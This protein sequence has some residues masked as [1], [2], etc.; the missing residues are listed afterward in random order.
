MSMEYEL[1]ILRKTLIVI[2][3]LTQILGL[4]TYDVN[5]DTLHIKNNPFKLIYS[6]ILP[7]VILFNY[8]KFGIAI[9]ASPG[10]VDAKILIHSKILGVAAALY[11][12]IIIVCYVT[13]YVQQHLTFRKRKSVIVK[14]VS[15]VELLKSLPTGRAN[16]KR[17]LVKF[18][19]KGIG[20]HVFNFLVLYF[21]L[22]R[23]G[24]LLDSYPYLPLFLYGPLLAVRFYE[25][26]FYGGILLLHATFK[27]INDILVTITRRNSRVYK[28]RNMEKY[29]QLSDELDKLSNFHSKLS[30]TTKGFNS[31][32]D[33]QVG[34]W[35]T[36]QLGGLIM[37]CFFQYVDI[38][39]LLNNDLHNDHN[40]ILQNV[41]NL[42]ILM[43]TWVELFLTS[44]ACDM[45]TTEVLLLYN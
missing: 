11:S 43:L 44:D 4:W 30:E 38:V 16:L 33:I 7:C 12:V 9:L 17:T 6:T 39:N 37:R 8:W 2:Y 23:S 35:M 26:I 42:V 3:F 10:E 21:N 20:F 1:K 15:V 41:V 14:M 5:K 31:I 34:L 32:F 40:M 25:N 27:R 22:S 13:L 36:L 18:F 19:F 24:H 28:K 45:L 29:C